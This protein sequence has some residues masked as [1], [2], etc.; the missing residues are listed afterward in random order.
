MKELRRLVRQG[1]H[2][3]LEFK[4]KANHPEKI[5]RELVAFA[6]T[7]GGTLLIGVDDDGSIYGSKYPSEDEYVLQQ[8][9]AK[10]IVPRLQVS[11]EHVPITARRAV[12]VFS[13][14][15]SRRKP[16]FVREEGH[17]RAYYRVRDMSVQASRE[18]V[19]ILRYAHRKK[20]V[21]IAFG[22]EERKLL[23]L[24]EERSKT[25]LD[26]TRRQLRISRRHASNLLVTL[27]RAG[28]LRIHPNEGEDYFTLEHQAFA[29]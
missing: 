21:E 2:L 10:Y 12:L 3:H 9:I 24:L 16:H 4:R 17:K 6:N 25:T 8:A 14:K 28:L 1:E 15:E 27:V 7:E 11:V 23:N 26:E 29:G 18:M 13:V 19:T 22:D 5:V 20:G